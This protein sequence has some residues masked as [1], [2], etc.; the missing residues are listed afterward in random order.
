MDYLQ[1]TKRRSALRPWNT[2]PEKRIKFYR[3]TGINFM[4]K[5]VLVFQ[6]NGSVDWESRWGEFES[7]DKSLC[8]AFKHSNNC[9][10][11]HMFCFSLSLKVCGKVSDITGWTIGQI[12]Q[13]ESQSWPLYIIK[14]EASGSEPSKATS[15][16][17]NN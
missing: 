10:F 14:I 16:C 7:I 8:Y 9:I 6:Q 12:R 1:E 13:F 11:L 5:D 15:C 17:D 4:Y 3:L 2:F